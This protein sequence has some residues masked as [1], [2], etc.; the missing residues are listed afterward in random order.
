WGGPRQANGLPNR[1]GRNL[2][3]PFQ[4]AAPRQVAVRCRLHQRRPRGVVRRP[5]GA[6]PG[7]GGEGDGF[8]L[9]AHLTLPD[10]Y[11][12]KPLSR[13]RSAVGT[14][15]SNRDPGNRIFG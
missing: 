2:S 8:L 14:G 10:L 12:G 1:W 5:P 13:P 6:L 7:D 4:P 11:S 3:E 15:V 9:D